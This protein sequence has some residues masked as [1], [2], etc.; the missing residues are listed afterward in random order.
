LSLNFPCRSLACPSTMP[1]MSVKRVVIFSAFLTPFRSGAE[2]CA[3]EVPPLLQD[4]YD[5]VIITARMQRSLPKHDH[6]SSGIPVLRVGFGVKADKWLF[7]LL[8]PL[9][10]RRFDPH[11]IHAI[12]ESYAGLALVVARFLSP[13]AARLLTLQSTNT[14]LFL[15]LIHHSAHQITAISQ[16]LVDRAITFG[17]PDATLIPNGIHYHALQEAT[18]KYP[19]VPGRI[20]FVGRLEPMKGVDTLLDVFARVHAGFPNAQLHLVGDGTLRTKLW[21]QA[22]ALGIVK[23]VTFLGYLPPLGVARE[24]AEAEIFCAL[25]R[26][27]ALG[28][29]FLEAQAS[30]CPVVATRVGGI[31]EIVEDLEAGLLVP[32]DDVTAAT[33][34]VET[35]LASTEL[36]H[37]MA[38]KGM[39]FAKAYDWAGIAEKYGD[40]YEKLLHA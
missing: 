25:S 27:E 2:A 17:C 10:A 12:L 26:S 30:G 16:T 9:A 36:R 6:L 33:E 28:N 38:K 11:L 18:K 24:F 3:E 19:D 20:L 1:Y 5:F 4:T 31:P 7:P 8:A 32:V 40:V 13:K 21:R 34:A 14:A 29:V 35:L 22:N 15:R 39:A 37:T 23:A